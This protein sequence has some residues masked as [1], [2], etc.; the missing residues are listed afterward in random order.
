M[1]AFVAGVDAAKAELVR[2]ASTREAQREAAVQLLD[3]LTFADDEFDLGY[4][5]LLA[6]VARR[7]CRHCKRIFT[8][9]NRWACCPACLPIEYDDG[10]NHSILDETR[11]YPLVDGF[12][13]HTLV[14]QNGT[15]HFWVVDTDNPNTKCGQRTV[16]A[17]DSTLGP[18]PVDI[19]V[20]VNRARC[21]RPTR[22]GKPCR[23]GPSCRYHR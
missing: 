10:E 7:Y 23:N 13:I 9:R 8:D 20:R 4:R 5:T 1:S 17:Y 22:S 3:R 6:Q 15:A 11:V 16:P 18:L 21:G 12:H 19:R 14:E 2:L